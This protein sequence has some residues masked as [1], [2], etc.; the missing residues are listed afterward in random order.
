ML[1]HRVT[2]QP[3][4]W[5]REINRGTLWRLASCSTSE[6]RRLHAY[7]IT[8]FA[9]RAIFVPVGMYPSSRGPYQTLTIT[10]YENNSY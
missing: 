2:V 1:Y 4:K 9:T 6:I 10:L 3:R 8:V 7:N 5:G